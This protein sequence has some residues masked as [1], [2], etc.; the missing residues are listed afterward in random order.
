MGITARGAWE[1]VKRHFRNLGVNTQTDEF[2]VVGVGDMAGDV[3]G[4]G[5]LLSKHLK[6]VAAFNHQHIFIDPTPDAAASYAERQR[7]FEL[8]R[9][10]WLDYDE[11]LL[12]AGGAIHS[13]QAKQIT[14]SP[15]A[16]AALGT[17]LQSLTPTE[18]ISIILKAP[19]DLLWNGGIGTYV[20]ASVE[21]HSDAAD[22]ANDSLRV[23]GCDL[24]VKVVGDGGNLGFT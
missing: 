24:R 22:R 15:E 4:N 10:S 7:L 20:K 19:V 17:D 2:T 14:L 21:T 9:S 23:N 13:R 3:F 16:Q 12:S 5:M 18:L 1:S 11:K 8:P 6:L